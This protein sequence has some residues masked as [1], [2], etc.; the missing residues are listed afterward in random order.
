MDS[1]LRNLL[2]TAD[3]LP[4][5]YL[6]GLLVMSRD[7]HFARLGDRAAGTMV[8][9]EDPVR[10]APAIVLDPPATPAELQALPARISLT[11]AERESLELLLRRRDI[12]AARRKE[13]ADLVAPVLARRLRVAPSDPVRFLALAYQVATGQMPEAAKGVA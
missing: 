3:F 5:G 10:V 12:S 13:L 2:R 8:V 9:I 1:V 7:S 4:A 6:L 11:A